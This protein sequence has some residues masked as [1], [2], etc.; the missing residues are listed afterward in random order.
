MNS[1]L[2]QSVARLLLPPALLYAAHLLFRGHQ[3][4]GGGFVAGLMTAAAII[5]E[6]VAAERRVADSG[7]PFRPETLIAAGLALAAATGAGALLLGYPFLTSTFAH[8]HIPILGE[9]EYST[10]LL[11]DVGVFLLVAGV[12]VSILLAIEE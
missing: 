3:L 12:T 11:F 10:V 7:L 2:L 9:I 6:Y 5:L 8:T 4:P 1:P